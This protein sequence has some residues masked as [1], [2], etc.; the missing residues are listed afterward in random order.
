MDQ[1]ERN[2]KKTRVCSPFTVESDSRAAAISTDGELPEHARQSQTREQVLEALPVAGVRTRNG[3]WDIKDLKPYEQGNLIS[4]TATLKSRK[5]KEKLKAAVYIAPEDIST[6]T[7][8]IR[9][10]AREVPNMNLGRDTLLVISFSYEAP[11]TEGEY[12]KMGNT[13]VIRAE[14]NRDLT[15]PELKHSASDN[16]FVVV[17][18]PDVELRETPGGLLEIEV[19]GVDTYDP[20]TNAIRSGEVEEIHCIMTDTDF[21]G[22]SFKV[23]RINFPN[24]T[25]DRQLERMKRDLQRHIDDRKWNRLMTA[26]TIPFDPP[27]SGRVAVKVIDK[28]GMETMR[29][30]EVQ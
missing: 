1:P 29:V 5:G 30:V 9:Q 8:H 10:A 15:I 11:A 26:T 25:K 4:H 28:A 2:P 14:A 13:L 20:G 16:S 18:E 24:Q 27:K 7:N 19:R 17:G 3:H 21:D 12:Q 23:R 22:Y 6:S